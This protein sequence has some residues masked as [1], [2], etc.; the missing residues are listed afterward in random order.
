MKKGIF[1]SL[2]C[3]MLICVMVA[4]MSFS[5]LAVQDA[6]VT[7]TEYYIENAEYGTWVTTS[8]RYKEN[9][10]SVYVYPSESPSGYTYV[11]T[12]CYVEGFPTNATTAENSYVRLHDGVKYAIEN[13][14]YDVGDPTQNVGV[15]AWLG[16]QPTSG[17]GT[18]SGLWSPDWTGKGDV[19][20][21]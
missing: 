13:T 3:V 14:I 10:S 2:I 20:L 11:K 12:L 8:G 7:D 5:A 19:T 16:L 6:N 21:V 17:S 4:S 15:L 9:D 18:L 1:G